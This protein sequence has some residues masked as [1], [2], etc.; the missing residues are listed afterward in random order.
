MFH[1]DGLILGTGYLSIVFLLT[2]FITKRQGLGLGDIQLILI[3]GYWIGDLR[4]FL[5][6]FLSA[7]TALIFWIVLSFIHGYDSKRA[8]PFG[9]FL[10]ITSI[11][12]YP[13]EIGLFS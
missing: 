4:I 7:L 6:L 8:L 11:L 9:S 5:V 10:S 1:I 2:W 3:L 12:I 13:I